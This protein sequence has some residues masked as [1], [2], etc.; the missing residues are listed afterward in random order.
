MAEAGREGDNWIWMRA[1]AGTNAN[2][3]ADI[4]VT[5]VISGSSCYADRRF[6]RLRIGRTAAAAA[7]SSCTTRGNSAAAAAAAATGTGTRPDAAG[8]ADEG[9]RPG[10]LSRLATARCPVRSFD[11]L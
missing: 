10:N 2:E 4:S 1:T 9:P 3:T 11:A 5:K 8:S 6:A 7:S